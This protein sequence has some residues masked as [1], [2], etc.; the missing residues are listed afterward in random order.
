[1]EY[2]LQLWRWKQ[3]VPTKRRYV[4]T[5]I[6]AITG[7]VRPAVTHWVLRFNIGRDTNYPDWRF[8]WF[9]QSLQ[10]NGVV[11]WLRCHRFLAD[12]FP[13]RHSFVILPFDSVESSYYRR[14]KITNTMELS[15]SWEAVSRSVTREFPNI[16]WNP[17]VHYRV[18]KSP[19]LVPILR[20][21]NPV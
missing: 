10:V 6:H 15:P 19:P 13:I 12:P 1:M 14:H 7:Q 5:R 9:S 16:L 17:K 21:I 18:H 11:H 3:H 20:Q 8:S 4:S 2:Y